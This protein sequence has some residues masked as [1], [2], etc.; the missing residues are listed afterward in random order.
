MVLARPWVDAHN[1]RDSLVA[2][3]GWIFPSQ[4]RVVIGVLP[5][6]AGLFVAAGE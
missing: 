1:F 4:P 3:E 5:V 6:P 2:G